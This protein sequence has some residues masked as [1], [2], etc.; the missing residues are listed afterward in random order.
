MTP[1][2][3]LE[4]KLLDDVERKGGGTLAFYAFWTVTVAA[5]SSSPLADLHRSSAGRVIKLQLRRGASVDPGHHENDRQ[6]VRH[7]ESPK[8]E[9]THH[10][11]GTSPKRHPDAM[12][13]REIVNIP[14]NNEDKTSS[15]EGLHPLARER[16]RT[17]FGVTQLEA[18]LGNP[19][20]ANPS[21]AQTVAE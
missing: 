6:T 17:A 9:R 12:Q 15:S 3:L 4:V 19:H 21:V 5:E 20:S 7:R 16:A 2:L 10:A 13:I 8:Q 14:Y 18:L 1:E 11:L